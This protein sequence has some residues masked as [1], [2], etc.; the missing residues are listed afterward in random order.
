MS[1]YNSVLNSE[2]FSQVYQL[3]NQYLDQ[4]NTWYLEHLQ[5]SAF[6]MSY[7]YIVGDVLLGLIPASQEDNWPTSLCSSSYDPMVLC[8]RKVQSCKTSA[9]VLRTNGQPSSGTS[10]CTSEF[11][12]RSFSVQL[13]DEIPFGRILVDQTTKGTVNQDSKTT[14]SVTRFR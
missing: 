5:L 11:Y 8:I 14:G 3:W 6:W 2:S 13:G 9:G 7:I 4:I 12:G 10:L 1:Q